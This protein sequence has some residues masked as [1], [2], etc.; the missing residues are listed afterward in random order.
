MQSA[1]LKWER[2]RP[3]VSLD[4]TAV[5][6]DLAWPH[7]KWLEPLDKKSNA[8]DAALTPEAGDHGRESQLG[9][10]RSVE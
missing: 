1:V 2:Y 5:A 3:S 10:I 8:R 9:V 4:L 6:V 7:K